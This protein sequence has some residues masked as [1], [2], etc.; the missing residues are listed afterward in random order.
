[1]NRASASAIYFPVESS[2][3]SPGMSAG[4]LMPNQLLAPYLGTKSPT[5]EAWEAAPNGRRGGG[6]GVQLAG[7]PIK[8]L[9]VEL[10]DT[11]KRIQIVTLKNRTLGPLATG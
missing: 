7:P 6:D 11:K 3:I 1:L 4:A 9:P 8:L 5:S 2:T 10:P